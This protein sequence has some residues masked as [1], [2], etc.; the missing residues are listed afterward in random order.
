[1]LFD[2][3]PVTVRASIRRDPATGVDTTT[4]AI[5]EFDGGVSTFT[6]STRA[7][8]DQRV[9]VY[10]SE[11][12]I[13]IDIPFNIPPDRPTHVRLTAG[14]DPPV[15]PATETLTFD[16]ADPYTVEAERFAAAILDDTPTPTP[17]EDAVANL[18]VIERIFEAGN[19]A[20]LRGGRRRRH[21]LGFFAILRADEARDENH[22]RG[23][24]FHGVR[25]GGRRGRLDPGPRPTRPGQRWAHLISSTRR[26][27]QAS[28]TPTTA[29]S[30]TRS[31]V[32]SPSSIATMTADPTCSSPA[33]AERP[34]C[35][36]T[37]ARSAGR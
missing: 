14:G 22:R 18:R 6:V 33:G 19:V 29:T 20:S 26:R 15:D 3:E 36:A 30:R 37:R 2:A 8:S 7:E 11:G 21:D 16:I 31:A 4:S 12:R 34:P 32:A 5:L 35:I 28:T 9:H 23:R 24:R 13:S 10:G 1:M 25:R 17:P 27:R